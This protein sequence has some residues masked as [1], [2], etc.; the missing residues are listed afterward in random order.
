MAIYAISDL[1][2]AFSENKPMDI[3]GENWV[4]YI[5]KIKTD[6]QKKVKPE[7]FVLLPGDFS[8]AMYLEETYEDFKFLDSLPGKKILLKGNHDYW[9]TTLNKMYA[10]LEKNNFKDIYFLHN[11]SFL[12]ENK[13][14]AGTRGWSEKEEMNKKIIRRENLRLNFSINDGIKKFGE[15]KEIIVCMHYPPYNSYEDLELSFTKT[16]QKYGVKQCIYGHL[17][18]NIDIENII[19][20]K[21]GIQFKLV[22][23]DQVDFKLKKIV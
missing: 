9:W 22:S 3:F 19:K 5:E 8:W 1:H 13:I 23:C 6:W 18:G 10:Y 4:N 7:D 15:D 14:I 11:N 12:C 17:H 20:E 2:L 16:M 21:H